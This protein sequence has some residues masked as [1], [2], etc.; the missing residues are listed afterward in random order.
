MLLFLLLF[1]QS[2]DVATLKEA[3]AWKAGGEHTF[4]SRIEYT[5]TSLTMYNIDLN[6]CLQW[7]YSVRDYQIAGANMPRETRY[8][9]QG[10]TG[11]PVPV[12]QLREMLQN[13]LAE[14][15][16]LKVRRETRML[17]VYELTVAKGGPKLPPPKPDDGVVHS[18]ESLPRVDNGSFLFTNATLADFAAKLSL[19][20]GMDHPVVDRTGIQGVYDI[21][22][23]GAAAAILQPD[24]PS[25]FTLVPEQLGLK[26]SP[27]KAPTEVLVV[28]ASA[29]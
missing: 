7:A 13:L 21:T 11:D 25:L 1:A 22:L 15:L 4:R 12:S 6:E 8:D 29:P 18:R 24:G 2:F 28:T 20:K 27:A 26:L 23:K 14:R 10:K 17:P 5:P 19:L 9:I 3:A 16:H